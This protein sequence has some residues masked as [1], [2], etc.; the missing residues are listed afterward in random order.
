M[1]IHSVILSVFNT[2]CFFFPFL[3][4][5]RVK[6]PTLKKLEKGF[7]FFEG[8]MQL[9]L[10]SGCQNQEL[11]TQV[12]PKPHENCSAIFVLLQYF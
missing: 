2:H 3:F 12:K 6:K 11:V 9:K 7:F 8:G 10:V 4:F 5:N 1:A